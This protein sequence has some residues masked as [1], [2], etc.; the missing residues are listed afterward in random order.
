MKILSFKKENGIP[1]LFSFLVNIYLPFFKAFFSIWIFTLSI[2]WVKNLS[3][4]LAH[5]NW[6]LFFESFHRS[7]TVRDYC[8]FHNR[9]PGY[10]TLFSIHSY[11]TEECKRL[12]KSHP[13]PSFWRLCSTTHT[14]TLLRPP[15]KAN[16]NTKIKW[17]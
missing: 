15:M 10:S 13:K 11:W 2:N 5:M 16:Q 9:N 4:L 8:Y 17:K 7:I 14:R 12:Q 3:F 1:Y 6:N